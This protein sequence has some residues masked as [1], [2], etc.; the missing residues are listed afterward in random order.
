MFERAKC[1]ELEEV[2]GSTSVG[3]VSRE[4][5]GSIRG[6]TIFSDDDDVIVTPDF[7]VKDVVARD[8]TSLSVNRELLPIVRLLQAVRHLA[9]RL[10]TIFSCSA[11]EHCETDAKPL[12]IQ[13]CGRGLRLRLARLTFQLANSQQYYFD[14]AR[15]R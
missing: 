3:S 7:S 14:I 13:G 6:R 8:E 12:R 9:A 4:V 15:S 5:V 11:R 10:R 2:R 1:E